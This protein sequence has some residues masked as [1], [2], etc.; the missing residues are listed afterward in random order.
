M[1][2]QTT[3]R[4][5]ICHYPHNRAA[6]AIFGAVELVGV[7]LSFAKEAE[8]YGENEPAEYVYKVLTGAVRIT[9]VLQD[10][11][12]QIEAFYFPGDVFGL[13]FGAEH[14]S[15]AEA[16]SSATIALVKRSTLLAAAT[17]DSSLSNQLLTHT[18]REL[19]QARRH[20]MLLVKTAQERVASFLIEI[21][22]QLVGGSVELPMSRQ[23][24]ADYLGL[25]IETVSRTLTQL[26]KTCTIEFATSRRMILRNKQALIS[27]NS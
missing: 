9:R 21:S 27:L 15:S 23:D 20:A 3:N 6:H 10:G 12:R 14:T 19:E 22:K 13:E 1:Q 7:P 18:A 8:I 25:T 4:T 2:T 24:I 16:V 26:Q 17:R 5:P 11:R